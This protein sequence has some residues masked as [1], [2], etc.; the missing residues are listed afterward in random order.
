MYYYIIIIGTLHAQ[1]LFFWY[2]RDD[3]WVRW[4]P[5]IRSH[6]G[7]Y[8]TEWSSAPMWPGRYKSWVI[9]RKR[10]S[11]FQPADA[12]QGFPLRK[13]L[14]NHGCPRAWHSPDWDELQRSSGTTT[15]IVPNSN[16]IFPLCMCLLKYSY[17]IK[18]AIIWST[19]SIL[20]SR[21]LG[22]AVPFN[23]LFPHGWPR[24]LIVVC[25]D[26]L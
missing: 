7:K 18:C 22:R 1:T 13:F 23:R 20:W 9:H 6:Q 5:T 3:E 11:A 8:W 15:I 19:R 10:W 2:F 26:S 12:A 25:R 4:K 14:W 16:G 24:V 21:A 17:S